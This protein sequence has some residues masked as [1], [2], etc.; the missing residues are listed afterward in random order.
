M[1]KLVIDFE[2]RNDYKTTKEDFNSIFVF[3]CSINYVK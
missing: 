1:S 3:S 2:F